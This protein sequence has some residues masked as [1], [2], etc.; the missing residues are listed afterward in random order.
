MALSP[1]LSTLLQ[2]LG[3]SGGAPQPQVPQFNLGQVS[4][5]MPRHRPGPGT[6]VSPTTAPAATTPPPAGFT[7]EQWAHLT[8]LSAKNPSI[9]NLMKQYTTGQAQTTADAAWRRT[10]PTDTT[11]LQ[12]QLSYNAGEMGMPGGYVGAIQQPAYGSTQPPVNNPDMTKY[13][14]TPALGEA[15]FYRQ[16]INGGMAPIAAMSPLGVPQGW[17]PGGTAT[18]TDT[19]SQLDKYLKGLNGGGK[20]N[21]GG[22]GSGRTHLGISQGAF[23]NWFENAV[24]DGTA[25]GGGSFG[26]VDRSYHP[27][28]GANNGGG[29]GGGK[30]NKT[31]APAPVA[32]VDTAPT[33]PAPSQGVPI[34]RPYGF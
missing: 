12:K 6:P 19:K 18:G 25:T 22:T 9:A 27:P 34:L 16:S 11:Q 13:G 4:N 5:G 21:G 28:L 30:K 31:P 33:T 7:A 1:N 29:G 14:Q 20:G 26:P 2:S 10:M 23:Q 32:P 24:R 8:Q 17:N 3:V 15:T